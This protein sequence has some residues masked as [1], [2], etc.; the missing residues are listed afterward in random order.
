MKTLLLF[1][2]LFVSSLSLWGQDDPKTATGKL[3]PNPIFFIDSQKVSLSDLSRY[4][5]DSIATVVMLYDTSATKL[6]GDDAKDGA[7][8]IETRSFARTMYISFFRKSSQ[9]YDSLYKETGNDGS[10]AYIINDKVQK[11]NYE[12]NLSAITKE[13]FEGLEILTKEKLLSVYKINDKEYGI[14]IHTKKPK[15]MYNVD[16]KF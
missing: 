12:G 7:V 14:L 5:P 13:L 11:G 15:D 9:S 3:G 10:F 16:K 4:N 8:I 1:S 6:Y 2:T